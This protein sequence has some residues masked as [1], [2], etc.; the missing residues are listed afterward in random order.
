MLYSAEIFLLM[1]KFHCDIYLFLSLYR[2]HYP[3]PTYTNTPVFYKG[4]EHSYEFSVKS[5]KCSPNGMLYTVLRSLLNYVRS[6]WNLNL[7]SSFQESGHSLVTFFIIYVV[8]IA[9]EKLWLLLLIIIIMEIRGLWNQEVIPSCSVGFLPLTFTPT[10][11]SLMPSF[12]QSPLPSK[13][14]FLSAPRG[15]LL[16]FLPHNWIIMMLYDL[17]NC[18]SFNQVSDSFHVALHI[19]GARIAFKKRKQTIE[20]KLIITGIE[21]W[22]LVQN[23]KITIWLCFSVSCLLG[24]YA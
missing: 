11:L 14:F 7:V 16:V 5:S 4:Y 15:F 2:A 17:L 23:K 8:I 3:L 22:N 19:G 24:T 12:F 6:G 13:H 9:R 18:L 10:S 20:L 21:L 1:F